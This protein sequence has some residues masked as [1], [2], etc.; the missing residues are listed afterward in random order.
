MKTTQ[1][2]VKELLEKLNFAGANVVGMIL[3]KIKVNY[4]YKS[5]NKYNKYDKYEKYTYKDGEK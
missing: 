1:P 3:N 4:T 5:H 2:N